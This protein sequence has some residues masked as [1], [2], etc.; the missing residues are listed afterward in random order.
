MNGRNCTS[1]R[2][3]KK[4]RNTIGSRDADTQARFGRNNSIRLDSGRRCGTYH[5]NSVAMD[6]A[7]KTQT[8]TI[9]DKRLCYPTPA[10]GN[11]LWRVS[12]IIAQVKISVSTGSRINR[13]A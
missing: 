2:I 1:M 13:P 3:S 8:G 11:M 4:N 10:V 9:Y 6:L 12:H 5:S 7:G